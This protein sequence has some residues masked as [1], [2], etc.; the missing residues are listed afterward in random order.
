MKPE[1]ECEDCGWQG[2]TSELVCSEEDSK[3][4]KKV[5]EMSFNRCPECDGENIVDYWDED[6][7]DE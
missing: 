2:Y 7:E 3:S 1:I 4:S 6:E 5:A